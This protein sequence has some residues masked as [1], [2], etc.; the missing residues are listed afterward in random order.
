[1]EERDLLITPVF[2]ILLT[3]IAFFMR[4]AFTDSVTRKYFIPALILRFFGALAVGM[5]YQFYYSGGDTFN[6]HTYGSRIIWEALLN[7]PSIGLQL[8]TSLNDY[9]GSIYSYA[10]RI[11]YYGDKGSYTVVKITSLFD[12]LTYSTYSSTALLFGVFGFSGAWAMFNVFYKKYPQAH[13]LLAL[14]ILFVPSVFFW[15]SGIFKDTITLAALG[16][17]VW[18][19]DKIVFQ[20]KIVSIYS[21]MLLFFCWLIFSIKIYVLLCFLPAIVLWVSSGAFSRIKSTVL[22]IM[23]LPFFILITGAIG[24]KAVQVIG[25]GDQ[26]YAL[27]KIPQ[28]AQITAYDLGYWTGKDA[29]SGY[30]LGELDGTYLGLFKLMPSA[31]NVSLFRP[32]LWEVKNPLMLMSALESS[33]LLIMTLYLFY[34]S[35]IRRIG[36]ILAHKDILFCMTFSLMFAFAV[37]I[38]TFNFGTLSRYKIPVMPFYIAGLVLINNQSKKDKNESVLH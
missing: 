25:E 6:Y 16:W 17:A 21:L 34:N 20:K 35:G 24:Y 32:Y 23:V 18:C 10:I 36:K 33:F 11:M 15:G 7:E 31:I 38:S 4:K 8:L 2:F 29:G 37:G 27:D 1:M 30:S 3:G 5:V 14:G 22:K 26:R 9:E 13:K 12:L 28:T 19:I